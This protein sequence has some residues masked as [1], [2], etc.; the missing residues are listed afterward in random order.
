VEGPADQ[1]DG[2]EDGQQMAA[3][4][5]PDGRPVPLGPERRGPCRDPRDAGR[6]RAQEGEFA[7]SRPVRSPAIS[8]RAAAR[9]AGAPR[10]KR[11]VGRYGRM[12]CLGPN[13]WRADG[14]TRI[15]R[16][17]RGWSASAAYVPFAGSSPCLTGPSMTHGRRTGARPAVRR[18]FAPGALRGRSPSRPGSR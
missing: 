4:P 1:V 18:G 17:L 12:P 9:S 13:A 7:G 11:Y 3:A 5:G 15:P 2:R 8:A 16:A 10:R 6:V 14:P